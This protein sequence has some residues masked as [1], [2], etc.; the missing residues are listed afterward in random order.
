MFNFPT[1]QHRETKSTH[2]RK[3]KLRG[4]CISELSFSYKACENIRESA[5]VIDRRRKRMEENIGGELTGVR[6]EE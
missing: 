1:S 4:M 5:S 6:R 2:N 3:V